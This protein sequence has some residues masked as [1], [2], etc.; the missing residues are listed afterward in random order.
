MG[1]GNDFTIT[2]DGTTGATLAGNPI[3][4]T[5]GGASSWTTSAGALTLTSAAAATWS[6]AAGALTLNGTG[7]VN[8]NEGGSTIIGISDARA[9]STTNTAS[10]DLDASGAI[11]INSSGG[12]LSVGND[13]VDQAVNI[14]TA[15]TRTLTL[16]IND[17]TDLTT[18][19]ALAPITIESVTLTDET[20]SGITS[21]FETGE[22]MNR[23]DVAYFKASDSKMWKADADTT[24]EM[25]VVAMAAEDIDV[26]SEATGLFLLFGFLGDNGTFPAY[27]VAGKIYA[28]ET[29]GP[30]TQTAPSDDGD[31]VQVLGWAVTAN[32]VFFN[33]SLDVI[34]HA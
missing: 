20:V 8:I 17:A 12:A 1:A 5:A 6:T 31:Y 11:Q 29:E 13:N 15:G 27:T 4:I 33:P 34:E 16:G 3:T 25:P 9:V 21:Q 32:S 26:S 2:H 24:A 30:P 19:N 28:P 7:G 23:G 10:I 18:I 14:A 22:D